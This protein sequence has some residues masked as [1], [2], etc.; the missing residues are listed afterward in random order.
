MKR[1]T[2][3]SEI[4]KDIDWD[5]IVIGGGATGV[6]I[7]VDAAQ[8]GFKTLLLEKY[9]FAKGT[10]SKSTKMLHGGVRY[11]AEGQ[12]KMVKTALK[13]R[14]L[15]YHNAPHL[16]RIQSF[17]VPSYGYFDRLKYLIGLK[18]YDWLSGNESFGKSNSLSSRQIIQKIPMV[19]KSG[20]KG[21]IQ[22]F[23]GQFD[24]ARLALNLAQTAADEGATILNYCEVV[25][26]QKDQNGKVI[27]VTA[28][29][30]ETGDEYHVKSKTIINAT[31]IFVGEVIKLEEPEHENMIKPSQGVHIVVSQKV[32]G[33]TDGLMI[34]KTSD[35]RVIF[36]VPWHGEVLLGTTDTPIAGAQIDPVPMKGEVD[37]I[38]ETANGYLEKKLTK[39]DILSVYTGIRPLAAGPKESEGTKK[40]SREH[41]ITV[42]DTGL[43]TITGGKWTT[44]RKMGE[45]AVNKAI[46]IGGLTQKPCQTEHLHIHGY[47]KETQ[48]EPWQVYGSDAKAIIALSETDPGLKEL[49][50]QDYPYIMAQVVWACKNEMALHI[51]DVLARRT[52]LLF[53]NAKAAKESALKVA[54]LMAETLH[55]DQ[56]W[57][58]QELKDFDHLSDEYLA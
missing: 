2:Q 26:I 51:E 46:E 33:G 44:Y 38:L 47:S 42:S 35:G 19:R 20:L 29:D 27:G 18:L 7:A 52:R 55:K 23:D 45:D 5:I 21:G 6:G 22:Y 54:G 48:P 1:E 50:H 9:D 40:I 16:S 41:K 3:L 24:D 12:I 10:S 15:A 32:L 25:A 31:G 57:I 56:A 11:L 13:E 58:D 30:R 36:G 34:P 37:F 8:R 39:A 14:G 17:I 28:K 43:I 49:I 53:L 4:K